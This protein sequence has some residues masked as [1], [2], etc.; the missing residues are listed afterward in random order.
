MDDLRPATRPAAAFPVRMIALDLD[1]TLIGHDFR[2]SD[3]TAAAI[4]E[5]VAARGQG[6]DRD[7]P[8]GQ[9]RRRV[10]PT[11]SGLADPIIGHQG[12]VVRA[13]PARP[14]AIDPSDLPFRAPVGR[15]LH[16]SPMSAEAARAAIAWC[17]E[18]GPRPARQR[19]RADRGLARRRPV[20]GLLGVPGAGGGHRRPTSRRRSGGR[21]RRSS[22]W[23]IRRGRW[24]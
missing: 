2:I 18:N 1:G 4:R 8:D 7:R 11:S 16:H 10:S 6:L 21:C 12:A 13:M 19:P 5:A 14:A 22:R 17:L 9:L 23:G 15:I 3:R 20:R 24:S